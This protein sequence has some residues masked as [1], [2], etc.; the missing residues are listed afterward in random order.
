MRVKATSAIAPAAARATAARTQRP[1]R[2]R[3]G[4][5]DDQ[6]VHQRAA[7]DV[8]AREAVG[9]QRQ[10]RIVED[11]AGALEG[12]LHQ[13]VER[14][15]AGDADDHRRR[16]GAIAGA[17]R[18]PRR[19]SRRSTTTATVECR[20]VTSSI[21]RVSSGVACARS[22]RASSTS[23]TVRRSPVTT[24]SAIDAEE[25][26][27]GDQQATAP[28][29]RRSASSA[30]RDGVAGGDDT[31]RA[32]RLHVARQRQRLAAGVARR[33]RGDHAAGDARARVAGRLR[34]VVVRA[35]VDDQRLAGELGR[36]AGRGRARG[37]RSSRCRL[38]SAFS[39]GRSPAW[40]SPLGGPCGLPVGLRWPPA[41]IA[42]PLEQ[43]PFSWTWK[44]CSWFGFRPRDAAADADLGAVGDEPDRAGR[45]VAAR[46][47]QRRRD[48]RRRRRASRSR[49][50]AAAARRGRAG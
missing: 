33:R 8:A 29:P 32:A 41:L 43:S 18:A 45:G 10:Q 3:E 4:P 36:A 2:S 35:D 39:D 11:R 9:R 16:R 34:R 42:S 12:E 7:G 47:L 28:T 38:P 15:A 20:S 22:Q 37:C 21:Q 14:Q 6:A 13:D 5:G 25:R 30:R 44:P 49:C 1:P 23:S 17:R 50:A 19:R 27:G 24:S 26:S 31:A 40:C 46:R 48:V